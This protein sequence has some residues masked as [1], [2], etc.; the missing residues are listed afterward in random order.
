MATYL[1]EYSPQFHIAY[2]NSDSTFCGVPKWTTKA[3]LSR[4]ALKRLRA[5]GLI[6]SGNLCEVCDSKLILIE[7]NEIDL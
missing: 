7:I 2:L 4:R 3:V 6:S 5:I 1:H